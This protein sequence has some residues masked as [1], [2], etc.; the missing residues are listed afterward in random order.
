MHTKSTPRIPFHALSLTPYTLH[1][2]W[3]PGSDLTYQKQTLEISSQANRKLVICAQQH[4]CVSRPIWPGYVMLTSSV[5]RLLDVSADTLVM[6]APVKLVSA[7]IRTEPSDMARSEGVCARI[8]SALAN[9]LTVTVGGRLSVCPQVYAA[10]R[11]NISLPIAAFEEDLAAEPTVW[12]SPEVVSLLAVEPGTWVNV[13]QV[14]NGGAGVDTRV[15]EHPGFCYLNSDGLS[16]CNIQTGDVAQVRAVPGKTYFAQVHPITP[17]MQ[18]SSFAYLD[19][20]IAE[21]FIPRAARSLEVAKLQARLYWVTREYVDDVRSKARNTVSLQDSEISED[22][23]VPLERV[24][25]FANG[26]NFSVALEPSRTSSPNKGAIGIT[27]LLLRR[28]ETKPGQGVFVSTYHEPL[29]KARVGIFNVEEVGTTVIKG[30]DQL[31]TLFSMPCWVELHNAQKTTSIDVIMEHDP[32]PRVETMV[33]MSRTTRELL[34][35]HRGD[36]VLIRTVPQAARSLKGTL[37]RLLRQVIDGLLHL[38]IGRRRIHMSTAPAHTWDDQAQVTR[39]D[40]EALAV[41]GIADGDRVRIRY[42]GKAISRIALARHAAEPQSTKVPAE[43]EHPYTL[44]PIQ[45][46]IN[47]DALG[48]YYL[49]EGGVEFGTVVEVERDMAFVLRKSLNLTILPII[50]T[51]VTIVTLFPDRPLETKITISLSLGILFYYLALS[52]ERSKVH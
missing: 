50:G 26:K 45:F 36:E 16:T 1:A 52:V 11:H 29:T 5:C 15:L 2:N 33:R 25:L 19:P 40:P 3:A 18:L 43:E 27:P 8:S 30:S 31:A 7:I 44:V 20:A 23:Y 24:C 35:L 51:V 42:R 4:D 41:L 22:G 32:Y 48:R 21:N 47:V 39:V 9:V 6:I 17:E 37:K 34:L 14:L 13:Y 12:V 46:H 38:L 28:S 10:R 49:A